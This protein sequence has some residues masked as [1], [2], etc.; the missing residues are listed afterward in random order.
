MLDSYSSNAA[1]PEE[2][3]V[4]GF[5]VGGIKLDPKQVAARLLLGQL[6]LKTNDPKAAEDEFETAILLQPASTEAQ[7]GLAKALIAQKKFADA[8]E[9]LEGSTS[10]SRQRG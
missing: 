6:Y 3:G 7:I 2:H 4:T 10:P 1:N 9:F 5:V 8:A